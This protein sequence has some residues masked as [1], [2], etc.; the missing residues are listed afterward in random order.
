MIAKQKAKGTGVSISSDEADAIVDL[1]EAVHDSG[2]E[3]TDTMIELLKR[4]KVEWPGL[5]MSASL[6]EEGP[7]DEEDDD[8]DDE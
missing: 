3:L 7:G 5:L 1:A 8:E 2:E 6:L 4:I